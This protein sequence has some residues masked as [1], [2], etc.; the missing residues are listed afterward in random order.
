[1]RILAQLGRRFIPSLVLAGAVAACADNPSP[2]G[3]STRGLD[4]RDD[5]TNGAHR[6]TRF[7]NSVKYRDQG[8]QPARGRSGNATL[9]ARGLLDARGI[10]TLDIATGELGAP[11]S[12]SLKKIQVKLFASNG[13]LQSTSNYNIGTTP[14]Y[15][16]TMG[17][18]IRGSRIQVQ[19]NI[20][21]L[22]GSRSDVVTVDETVKLRPDLVVDHVTAPE[23]AP[24]G[25]PVDIT[26]LVSER[27][28]DVGA[29]ADC[30]LS[31][32]GVEID[33]AVG[34]WVDA[35]R[36]VSCMFRPNFSTVGQ[37]H[38][39]VN[40]VSVDPGDYDLSNNSAST[41]VEI[42]APTPVNQFNW[43]AEFNGGTEYF[44]KG[45]T[46]IN[47]TDY[48]NNHEEVTMVE[49]HHRHDWLLPT[50]YGEL[51]DYV[52]RP[53][54]FSLSTAMDGQP[55]A[56]VSLDPLN[57]DY[58]NN[59]IQYYDPQY[60]VVTLHSECRQANR[61][62]PITIQGSPG[63]AWVAQVLVCTEGAEG[64][65]IP[66][67]VIRTQFSFSTGAGD[68]SYYSERYDTYTPGDGSPGYSY[69]YVGETNYTYGTLGFGNEWSFRIEVSG[70]LGTRVGTGK[71]PLSSEFQSYDQ[72]YYC[73]E[74]GDEFY[75]QNVCTEYVFH[76]RRWFG[77][78]NGVADS[79]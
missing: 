14:T 46:V 60:G 47:Y 28:G 21:G 79:P 29:R 73:F 8:L 5:A 9:S 61:L 42:V 10:T 1:M 65:N 33:R 44:Y 50:A 43:N 24:V 15:Q 53:L 70:P 45:S 19:A 58:Y 66:P 7:S 26:A 48:L 13:A 27:N 64:D 51:P 52:G 16:R 72:P 78:A 68:V 41:S 49:D 56:E 32:D 25:M 35:G 37:K 18:R 31:A 4:S 40:L 2:T 54:N 39:T 74:Y 71:V 57:D 36:S 30:V 6:P 34:T 75:T 12:G 11:S 20:V 22:D 55:L 76:W 63:Y 59:D 17:G 62:A 69:S 3:L 38:L 77:V 67:G 23:H